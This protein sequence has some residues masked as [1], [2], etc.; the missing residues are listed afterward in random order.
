MSSPLSGFSA[1]QWHTEFPQKL[2]PE[3]AGEEYA[4]DSVNNL[5]GL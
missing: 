2:C 4:F 1:R 3:W 5:E